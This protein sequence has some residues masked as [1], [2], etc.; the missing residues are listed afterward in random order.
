MSI[1]PH[2]I[3]NK[4]GTFPQAQL[5]KNKTMGPVPQS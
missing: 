1:C 2:H 5:G 4:L 3:T